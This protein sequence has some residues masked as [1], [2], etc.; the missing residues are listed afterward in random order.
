MSYTPHEWAPFLD[1][2]TVPESDP[3]TWCPSGKEFEFSIPT[4]KIL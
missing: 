3:T 4:K 2:A 1:S